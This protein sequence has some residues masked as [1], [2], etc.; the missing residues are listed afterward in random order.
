MWFHNQ[1]GESVHREEFIYLRNRNPAWVSGGVEKNGAIHWSE[2]EILL[3]SNDLSIPSISY[4]DFVEENGRY[5]VTETQKTVARIH[6][7][8]PSLL[9]AMWNQFEA[10]SVARRGLALELSGNGARAGTTFEMP[11]LGSLRDGAGFTLDFWVKLR[12][13]TPGQTILDT[14]DA[15][16]KGIALT[17]TKRWTLELTLSDGKRESKWESDSGTHPGTL[18]SG[19]WQHVSVIVDSGPKIVSFVIDGVFNDGGAV[20]QFGWGRYDPMLDDVNGLQRVAVA[21]R[22]FGEVKSFRIYDRYLRTSESVGNY[23]AGR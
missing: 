18:R 4:P 6:E 17:T 2:P 20:R 15:S 7:I 19:V 14:R 3:Y 21:P 12:E 9:Q 5:W 1:G 10:K 23:R 11:R 8:D 16:G 22:I 13:L